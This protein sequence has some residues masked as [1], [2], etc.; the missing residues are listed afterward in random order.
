MLNTN[1]GIIK[2]SQDYEGVDYD[3]TLASGQVVASVTGGFE[4]HG[5][6]SHAR[7]LMMTLYGLLLLFL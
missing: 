6:D 5:T 2:F 7:T 3:D 1:D 4:V